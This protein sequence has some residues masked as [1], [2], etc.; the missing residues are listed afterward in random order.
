MTMR[1]A[2]ALAL[3]LLAAPASAQEEPGRPPAGSA[4]LRGRLVRDAGDGPLA[5]LPVVLYAAPKQG[6][7]GIARTDSDAEGRFAFE[8]I[9]NDPEI[10]YF[11]GVRVGELPYGARAS[12]AA[13]EAL[14]EVEVRI[15]APTAEAGA[16]VREGVSLRIGRGCGALAVEETWRLRNPG[17]SPVYLPETLRG[18]R[19]PLFESRLPE[20]ASGVAVALGAQGLDEQAGSVR[21]W[22]PLHP[23][24][25]EVAFGY[26]LPIAAGAP[27]RWRFPDGSGPIE[28]LAPAKGPRVSG[29]GLAPGAPREIDGRAFAT[30]SAA[31]R[32]GE[33][34][35]E[36]RV[37]V[38][39]EAFAPVEVEEAQLFAE[40]DDAALVV[41][42]HYR[43]AVPGG[44]P[45][46]GSPDAPLICVPLPESAEGLR[47]S[48]QTL[49][50]GAMPDASG[51]LA[52]HGPIP[53]GE[54]ALVLRYR[55]PV[56]GDAV[57]LDPRFPR[58]L[59]RLSVFV[60]DT[61][62][63]ARTTRLHRRRPMRTQDRTYLHLEGFEIEAGESVPIRLERLA[64]RGAPSRLATAGV[65]L[66]LA[67]LAIGVL[68]APLRGRGEE[69]ASDPEA[70]ELET[71]RDSV[72]AALASLEEDFETGK[73]DASDY[74]ALRAELRVRA[75]ALIQR[76][77]GAAAR[78]PPEPRAAARCSA[79][80][81]E[82]APD[83]RFC[84]RC[85]TPLA[86]RSEAAR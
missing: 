79:C 40:L 61:G 19:R 15:A 64:P 7:P 66:G 16:V 56:S 70:A 21:F 31:A 72:R 45:L 78:R 28:V 80:A 27:L 43:L 3:W 38:P 20:G 6:A 42:A 81:A 26:A 13:G 36:L 5:G 82:L 63:A 50:M 49:E 54:S 30:A 2:L 69:Q 37:E 57:D 22:G 86:A 67:T 48:P 68:V 39:D 33:S 76:R 44:A 47:F 17:T 23:G 46:E 14:H 11:V 71:E 73:L 51:Q 18:E 77:E 9:S 84:H 65:A 10:A 35:L 58:R 60:A 55:L 25:H 85:G 53:A 29:D 75:A 52:L 34:A 32:A 83:A 74:E 12:F 59:P 4:T 62:V 1:A 8:G 24:S 41:D